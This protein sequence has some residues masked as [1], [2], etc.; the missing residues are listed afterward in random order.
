MTTDREI[1]NQNQQDLDV[2]ALT[3][4]YFENGQDSTIQK[5]ENFAK[6]VPR[7][8]LAKFLVRYEIFKRILPV[9]GSIV[10]AGVLRGGGLFTWAKLSAIFEPVNHTRKIIGFDTFAGFPSV[11]EKDQLGDSSHLRVGGLE[12]DSYDDILN[13][14]RL[15]DLNRP[16]GHIPKIELVKGDIAVTM[17]QYVRDNPHL[18]VSL[19]YLDV[20]LYEPTKV[21]LQTVLERMPKGSI[22]VFDEL[23]A[24][25][26]PGET[27]AVHDVIGIKNLRIERFP[28]DS[29]VSY[30]VL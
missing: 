27:S 2:F 5:I 15:Y 9:N 28:T 20:D 30:A 17:P 4:Q 16:V 3:S 13:G 26:F 19:L 7:Q 29:Y 22:I 25:M 12:A 24:K 11:H 10:E 23:N 8:T 1:K 6:Y 21:A 18:V 14:I